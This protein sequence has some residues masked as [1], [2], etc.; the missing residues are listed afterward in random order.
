MIEDA[1]IEMDFSAPRKTF[2]FGV[3]DIR[4]GAIYKV[5]M[6]LDQAAV[7]GLLVDRAKLKREAAAQ[8]VAH[9][10]TSEPYRLARRSP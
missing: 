8:L 9:W 6:K 3:Q 4:I 7:I 1:Q 5:G 2:R 10:L